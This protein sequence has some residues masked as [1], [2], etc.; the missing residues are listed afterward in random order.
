MNPNEW[1]SLATR[2]DLGICKI[3][4]RRVLIDARDQMDNSRLWVVFM[5]SWVLGRDG[6][7]YYEPL[8]SERTDKFISLTRFHSPEIAFL[9]WRTLVT[10][11]KHL[12][13]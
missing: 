5:D 7:W 13:L 9:E 2:F 4:K 3:Y 6:E 1:L 8:P 11:E 12:T 10:N